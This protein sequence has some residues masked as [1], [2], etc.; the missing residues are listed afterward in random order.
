[1]LSVNAFNVSRDIHDKRS[2]LEV[3]S[4]WTEQLEE[5][6]Y[7]EAYNNFEM[8]ICLWHVLRVTKYPSMEE[9][10]R[11]TPTALYVPHN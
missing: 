5:E 1:M 7:M 6:T 10:A 2:D 8:M 9:L 11:G 4:N 3:T